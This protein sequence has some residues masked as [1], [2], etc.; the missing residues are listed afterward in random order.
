[1]TTRAQRISYAVQGGLDDTFVQNTLAIDVD[2][3]R[4]DFLK[5][6]DRLSKFTH[7]ERFSAWATL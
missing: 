3:M 7:I 5:A 6:L 1:M 2:Q 4:K